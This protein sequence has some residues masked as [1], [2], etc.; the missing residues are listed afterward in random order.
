MRVILLI[1][2]AGVTH[3]FIIAPRATTM[4]TALFDFNSKI[5]EQ[6]SVPKVHSDS[7]WHPRDPASTVPQLMSSVWHQITHAGNMKK[8][9][10]G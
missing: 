2:L 5:A 4:T 10:R 1:L 3:G 6:M 8:G 9:V 7:E